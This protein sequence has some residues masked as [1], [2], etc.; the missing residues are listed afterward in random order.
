MSI[1]SYTGSTCNSVSLEKEGDRRI[2]IVNG[3]KLTKRDVKRLNRESLEDW[4]QVLIQ[5]SGYTNPRTTQ[6]ISKVELFLEGNPCDL[7]DLTTL[8][9]S[10]F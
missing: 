6:S 9:A 8:P 1:S 5:K 10:A 7:R 4:N 2:H 3:D